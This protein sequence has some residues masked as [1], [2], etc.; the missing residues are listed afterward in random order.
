L[1]TNLKNNYS[2][3]WI[4]DLYEVAKPEN[5]SYYI[6]L[7]NADQKIVLKSTGGSNWTIHKK[8]NKA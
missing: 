7:E 8:S 3:Y 6:T 5:T 1:Q 2:N 4:S